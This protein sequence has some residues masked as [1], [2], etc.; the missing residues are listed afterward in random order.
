MLDQ[1]LVALRCTHESSGNGSAESQ[2]LEALQKGTFGV[3]LARCFPC[4]K[5]MGD[6]QR[7]VSGEKS[8]HFQATV[9]ATLA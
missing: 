2:A 6:A 5:L 1:S 4:K 3:H 8:C 9:E 7:R